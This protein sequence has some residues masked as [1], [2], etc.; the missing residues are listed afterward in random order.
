M[1][2]GNILL[3]NSHKHTF[4]LNLTKANKR[5][6]SEKASTN[7]MKMKSK[8]KKATTKTTERKKESGEKGRIKS[9]SAHF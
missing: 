6:K 2:A 5:K 9:K 7:I 3:T 8:R 1:T 4:P